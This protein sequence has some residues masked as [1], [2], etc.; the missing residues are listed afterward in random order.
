MILNSKK[1]SKY[2][3][4]NN[5]NELKTM[6]GGYIHYPVI[7]PIEGIEIPDYLKGELSNF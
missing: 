1:I 3:L 5:K 2:T 7:R 6:S 4:K